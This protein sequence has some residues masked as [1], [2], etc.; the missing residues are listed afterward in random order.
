MRFRM[1]ITEAG[2][3][4]AAARGSADGQPAFAPPE[5]ETVCRVA[6][7]HFG[8]AGA[9][10][11]HAEAGTQHVLAADGTPPAPLPV[12]QRGRNRIEVYRA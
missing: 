6:R 5:L 7:A 1:F 3:A 12:G 9:F 8:T 11:A 2:D 4:P 10:V